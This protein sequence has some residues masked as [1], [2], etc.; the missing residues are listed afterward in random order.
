MG[1]PEG[2]Y[3]FKNRLQWR[4]WLSDHQGTESLAWLVL[5]KVKYP[6]MGL[7]LD[8]AVEEALCF[9]WIDGTL[10]RMDEKRYLLRFSL[11]RRDSIWSPRNI[12]SV[13]VLIAEGNM[14]SAGL[15]KI[16]EAKE[17]GQWEAAIR[18]EDVE[19]IPEDLESALR[20]VGGAIVTYQ[21]LPASRKKRYIY[22]LQSAKRNDTRERRIKA[23]IEEILKQ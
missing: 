8:E 10:R 14:T 22:W 7:M 1:S 5:Y 2:F 4:D 23:I 20:K 18:R 15:L 3:E 13:D 19:L 21:A 6:G 16:T 9:G 12:Q 17:N 11:C